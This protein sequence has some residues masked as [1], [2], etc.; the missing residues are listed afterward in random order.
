VAQTQL[1]FQQ[2]SSPKNKVIAATG[3]AAVG[4]ASSVILIWLLTSVLGEF[5]IKP[6]QGVLDAFNTIFTT[7][8]TLAAAY[9]TPPG[10]NEGVVID[11][12]GKV[13]SAISSK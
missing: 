3:G 12:N 9:F 7:L 6:P 2:T 13:K 10:A 1:T 11:A 4:S 5:Q 8:A